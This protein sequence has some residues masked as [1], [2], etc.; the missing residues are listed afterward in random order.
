MC[1]YLLN[2]A[3]GHRRNGLFFYYFHL[4]II[5]LSENWYVHQVLIKY[6]KLNLN[7]P[8]GT[9]YLVLTVAI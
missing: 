7:T 4:F 5:L 9:D 3:L 2:G 6:L 1:V 8:L